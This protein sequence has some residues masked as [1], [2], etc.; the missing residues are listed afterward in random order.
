MP[1]PFDLHLNIKWEDEKNPEILSNYEANLSIDN[2][3][4][5]LDT[6]S[7]YKEDKTLV[8]IC[9]K[10]MKSVEKLNGQAA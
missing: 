9:E 7:E 3:R 2:L 6:F 8:T 5:D 4:I 10:L 1:N